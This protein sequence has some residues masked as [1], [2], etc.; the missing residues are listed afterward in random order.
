MTKS[1]SHL[2]QTSLLASQS[3]EIFVARQREL[4]ELTARLEEALAGRGRLV[5]LAG[6]PGI[7]KTRLAAEVSS[8][9]EQS[10]AQVWWGRCYE[11]AGAPPNWPWI[12]LIRGYVQAKDPPP[13]MEPE[14]GRF[15]L[16]DSITTLLK[17]VSNTQ[18]LVLILEDLH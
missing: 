15:R 16:I 17:I 7:G 14:Q 10:G 13:T 8:I 5:M 1:E 12:Q 4:D 11:E 2:N 3:S 6:E 9:A 18:P